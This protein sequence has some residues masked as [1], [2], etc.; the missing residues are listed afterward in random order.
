[1]ISRFMRT[2]RRLGG[3]GGDEK[4]AEGG[5]LHKKEIEEVSLFVFVYRAGKQ[6]SSVLMITACI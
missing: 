5:G 1:M 4:G 3:R 6:A 2:R